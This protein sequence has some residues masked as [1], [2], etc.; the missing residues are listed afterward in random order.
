MNHRFLLA[1]AAAASF[2]ACASVKTIQVAADGNM[3]AA[4]IQVDVA[5]DSPE[6]RAVSVNQYFTPGNPVRSAARPRTVRFGAGQPPVQ[7]IPAAGYGSRAVII[8]QLPG[9]HSDA[10]G[11]ADSRR[12]ILPLSGKMP[13][14]RKLTPTMRVNVSQGGLTFTPVPK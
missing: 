5:K 3:A 1:I 10:P 4:S 12:K 14:G 6:L 9:G 11:D 8:A 2:S 7:E 13:D